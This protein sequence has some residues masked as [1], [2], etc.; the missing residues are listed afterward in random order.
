MKKGRACTMNHD[1]KRNGTTTPFAALNVLDGSVLG[2]CMQRHRRSDGRS[3]STGHSSMRS[4][5]AVALVAA[6]VT[7][8]PP[9]ANG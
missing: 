6:S 9:D 4:A 2:Q 5:S 8:E 1:Y 7:C 3:R